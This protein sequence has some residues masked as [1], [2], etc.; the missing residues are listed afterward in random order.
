MQKVKRHRDQ[1]IFY[2]DKING[3]MMLLSSDKKPLKNLDMVSKF[4][5]RFYEVEDEDEN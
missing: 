1:R 2:I 4:K 5:V 3:V